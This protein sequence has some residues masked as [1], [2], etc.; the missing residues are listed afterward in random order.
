MDIRLTFDKSANKL[1][2]EDNG[3]GM[4]EEEAISCLGTIAKSG[5]KD[6]MNAVKD[7]HSASAE[8][9]IGQFG[10]GFYSTFM[11]ADKV[12]VMT[13]RWDRRRFLEGTKLFLYK[14]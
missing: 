4:S 3:V 12:D 5:S 6:F 13:R 2:I 14:I 11:V 10:V 9:I 8:S 1:I 7:E